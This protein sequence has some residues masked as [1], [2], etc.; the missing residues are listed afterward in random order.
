MG[1]LSNGNLS[2]LIDLARHGDL[3]FD[4]ILSAELFRHY[5]PDPETYFGAAA[6]LGVEPDELMLAAAHNA[7]LQAGA[8]CGLRTAFLAR[9]TE[10]GPHQKTDFAAGGGIDLIAHDVPDLAKR[11]EEYLGSREG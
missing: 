8:R 11:L 6:L 3:R 9:P 7:D 1:T 5:K 2:L 4:A 10:Y